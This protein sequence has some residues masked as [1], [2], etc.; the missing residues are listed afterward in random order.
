MQDPNSQSNIDPNPSI[1]QLTR[2][3]RQTFEQRF[4]RA[5]RWLAAAPGRVNLIGEHTD[6]NDGFVLPMAIERYTVVAADTTNADFRVYSTA[7]DQMVTWPADGKPAIDDRSKWI[8]YVWGVLA[9]SRAAGRSAGPLDMIVDS[10]VPVGGGLSSSAA[11]EVATGL[12]ASELHGLG[13]E[14]ERIA[15]FGRSAENDYL[16]VRCGI[17]DQ[18]ASLFGRR[19]HAL[20]LDCRSL[21]YQPVPLPADRV[22]VLVADTGLRRGLT[23]SQFNRRL[24]ECARAV[25]H[26]RQW[27]PEA[28]LTAGPVPAGRR[29]LPG[30]GHSRPGTHR[31]RLLAAGQG[32][33]RAPGSHPGQVPRD[34]LGPTQ[35]PQRLPLHPGAGS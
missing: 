18:F 33:I 30:G 13:V 21:E 14:R 25:E 7:T 2:R 16:G 28:A 1:E 32:P 17:M 6:Y 35:C 10:S 12:L 27:V 8:N 20:L 34:Q 11:L 9:E 22:R 4:G 29:G 23:N 26:L 15:L 24:E 31:R 3:V 19:D 5:P